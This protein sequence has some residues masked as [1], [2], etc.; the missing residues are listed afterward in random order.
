MLVKED[1]LTSLPGDGEEHIQ[2]QVER[3]VSS[4]QN[5][6]LIRNHPLWRMWLYHYRLPSGCE[7]TFVYWRVHHCIADGV[8]LGMIFKLV[9]DDNY[10]KSSEEMKREVLQ[11]LGNDGRKRPLLQRV[12][13]PILMVFGCIVVVMTW[14][15][16]AMR[17]LMPGAAPQLLKSRHMSRKWTAAWADLHDVERGKQ[18]CAN[19]AKQGHCSKVTINDLGLAIVSGA[20]QRYLAS[21]GQQATSLPIAIPV[22]MRTA[23]NMFQI[24]NV[25]GSISLQ[26]PIDKADLVERARCI[27]KLMRSKKRWP[28]PQLTFLIT[29][30]CSRMPDSV[31]KMVVD[32]LS[33]QVYACVSNVRGPEELLHWGGVPM[34]AIYGLV[35]PP[36]TIM[37]GIGIASYN[38]RLVVSVNADATLGNFARDFVALM[39]D[40]YLKYETRALEISEAAETKAKKK[41]S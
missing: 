10:T 21:R 30:M 16:M 35:P 4:H 17:S 37:V 27:S 25:I 19:L 41:L 6:P 12:L 2:R 33:S 9:A 31:T 1:R 5:E 8:S 11:Q 23:A 15:L 34:E 14:A 29:K 22:N 39:E 13:S 28:E 40:E 38:G 24:G 18:I 32:G 3:L 36:N 20:M 26:L 7:G